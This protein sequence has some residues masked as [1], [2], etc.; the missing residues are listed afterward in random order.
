MKRDGKAMDREKVG[1]RERVRW[2]EVDQERLM[3]K[4]MDEELL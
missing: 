3:K 1:W 2:R 4:E